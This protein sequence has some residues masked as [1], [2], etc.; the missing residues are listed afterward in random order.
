MQLH[1]AIAACVR[2]AT[3]IMGRVAYALL[4][5]ER[6]LRAWASLDSPERSQPVLRPSRTPSLFDPTCQC[7]FRRGRG[8][9]PQGGGQQ[10]HEFAVDHRGRSSAAMPHRIEQQVRD[11]QREP[12][13]KKV[14]GHKSL[15]LA[16]ASILSRGTP[17]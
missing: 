7:N 15:N 6:Y 2:F 9:A 8:I 14:T 4:G 16:V 10:A 5:V 1:E 11:P 17:G 3:G 13:D 12:R